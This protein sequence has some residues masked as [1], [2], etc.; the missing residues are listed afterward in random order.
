MYLNVLYFDQFVFFSDN[1]KLFSAAIDVFDKE[2]Q[3]GTET[4]ISC[5]ITEINKEM[6]ISWSGISDGG[7]Y[8]ETSGYYDDETNSQTGTLTVKSAAVT[9]DKIY[10]CTVSSVDNPTSEQKPLDVKLE[11]YSKQTIAKFDK[12]IRT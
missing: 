9:E 8:V 5:K 3:M 11:V 4:T 2:V 6:K 1:S 12:I 7:S 10:T